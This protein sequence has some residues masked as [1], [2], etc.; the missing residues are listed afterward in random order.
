MK[1][2][3]S[4]V[5]L[6]AFGACVWGDTAEQIAEF[7]EDAANGDPAAQWALGYTYSY[8]IGVPKDDKEAAKWIRKAAEQGNA[9]AQFK[10]W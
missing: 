2:L 4:I 8:G 9:D 1:T 7:K 3:L 10:Y 6:L 5:L